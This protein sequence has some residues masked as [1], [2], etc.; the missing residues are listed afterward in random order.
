MTQA[1]KAQRGEQVVASIL[2]IAVL[3]KA[4]ALLSEWKSAKG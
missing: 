3:F 1:D 2:L 4:K